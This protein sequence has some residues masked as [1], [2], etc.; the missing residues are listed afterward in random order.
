MDSKA[1]DLQD[2]IEK[3][4]AKIDDNAYRAKKTEAASFEARRRSDVAAMNRF[5]AQFLLACHWIY[6]NILSPAG[7]FASIPARRLFRWYRWLWDKV[8]YRQDQYKNRL[9]SKT[10][11]GLLLTATIVFAWFILLPLLEF[12]FDVGL[13]LATVRKDEVVYLTNSQEIIPEENVHSVQGCHSLPCTDDNS[14][15]FRIRATPFN[16]VWSLVQGHGLFFPDY[17]AAAVPLTI[18]RC[19]ITSY[20]MRIKF[21]VRNL[22][23][24]PDVL[25]TECAPLGAD[26]APAAN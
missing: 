8:V 22:D 15:Y 17:V 21:V 11:A 3:L 16:E 1:P 24:Y 9:F 19:T 14:V 20:G 6:Q 13:Y 26:A 4:K 25:R 18:S 23:I 10:R 2:E 12:L 7:R 5:V